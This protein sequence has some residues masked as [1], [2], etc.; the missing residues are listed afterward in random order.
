MCRSE[1]D[2]KC[3]LSAFHL[4]YWRKVSQLNPELTS[5]ACLASQLVQE[6]PCHYFLQSGIVGGSI[7]PSDIYLIAKDLYSGPHT[8]QATA[9]FYYL[10]YPYVE[11]SYHKVHPL[12]VHN[13]MGFGVVLLPHSLLLAH[14]HHPKEGLL[15]GAAVSMFLFVLSMSSNGIM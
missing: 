9:C 5:L 14:P 2:V 15:P 10:K 6:I 1:I 12:K 11:F 13:L 7:E 8:W 4:I 3:L